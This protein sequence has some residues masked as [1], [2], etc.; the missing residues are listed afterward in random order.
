M[1]TSAAGMFAALAL[2][3]ALAAAHV[4]LGDYLARVFS[5]ERHLRVERALYRLVRVDPNAQ[6]RWS[7]YAL[8]LLGHR[9][10]GHG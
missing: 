1:G 7:V 9:G 8:S 3:A 5:S 6:Q 4:P 2:V 10:G